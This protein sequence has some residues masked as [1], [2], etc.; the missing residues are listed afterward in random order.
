[1][2]PNFVKPSAGGFALVVTVSMMVLLTLVVVAT[3]SLS[4]ITLRAVDQDAA[5]LVAKANARLALTLAIG[6]LQENAGPDQRVTATADLAG[7][8]SSNPN[9]PASGKRIPKK[10][11]LSG[12]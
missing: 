5:Q 3:L 12:S 9:G 1:M 4:T 6:A 10:L 2:K 8:G 7:K 11:T